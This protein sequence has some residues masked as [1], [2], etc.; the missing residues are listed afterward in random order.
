M[1]C[2]EYPNAIRPKPHQ[3]DGGID[4]LI[5]GSDGAAIY[6]I[7]GYTGNLTSVQKNHIKK[8]WE[9]LLKYSAT[10]SLKIAEWNIVITENLTNPQ[11]KWLDGL[12]KDA[13]FPCYLHTIDWVEAL[14]AKYPDV[15]D[16]Y[17]HDGKDRLE[18][19][20]KSYLSIIS[21]DTSTRPVE[22]QERIANLHKT[23]NDLDPLYRYDFSVEGINPGQPPAPVSP[24]PGLV[25]AV[26]ISDS[27]RR[28]TYKIFAR[29]NEALNE[30]PIPGRFTIVAER[31]S[32]LET[33]LQDW[34]QFG[35]P[36]QGVPVRQFSADLPGG[37]A[38][39]QTGG[40]ISII[41]SGSNSENLTEI[42][43]TVVD[44][45]GSEISSLDFKTEEVTT[46][47]DKKS[48]RTA[49]RERLVG[50]VTYELRIG[51]D[52][53]LNSC[54]LTLIDITGKKP[55]DILPGL[56]FIASI[57]PTRKLRIDIKDGPPLARAAIPGELLSEVE[58]DR[59]IAACEAISAIQRVTFVRIVV[60]DLAMTTWD[61]FNSWLNSAALLRGEEITG[62]WT[63]V[64]AHLLQGTEAPEYDV[65]TLRIQGPWQVQ[66]GE[67]TYNIGLVDTYW[68]SAHQDESRPPEQHDDHVDAWYIPAGPNALSIRMASKQ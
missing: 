14:V 46:G 6:Q 23:L 40:S 17:L 5:P 59:M 62:T 4:V 67:N 15:I 43:M 27:S 12:I 68:A 3:G 29:F 57:K 63:E 24:S 21:P 49:G 47:F 65:G 34:A 32:E 28:I 16:Y 44:S 38:A 35:T 66:I 20:I 37:F 55:N 25:A 18:S 61:T 7:K 19:S 58:G 56:R 1:L 33:Q 42:T 51:P 45:D 9:A 50:S 8:S 31:G 60:P 54:Q 53:G 39:E 64:K 48:I 13:S 22:S 2:R 10:E 30:R 11:R 36:L 52:D 41:P 26:H